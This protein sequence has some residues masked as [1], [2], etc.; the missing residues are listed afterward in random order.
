MKNEPKNI[1]VIRFSSIGDIVLT[2]PVLRCIKKKY[3]NCK[4]HFLSK[5]KYKDAFYANPFIDKEIYWVGRKTL[6]HLAKQDFDWIIDLHKN[7]RTSRIRLFLACCNKFPKWISF[8]KINLPKLLTVWLKSKSFLPKEHIVHRYM[9]PLIKLGIPFDDEGLDYFIESKYRVNI[10]EV[11][12]GLQPFEYNVYALGGQHQT[13]ILPFPK[14]LELLKKINKKTLLLGGKEDWEAAEKLAMELPY[15]IN[16]C[17]KF[18]LPQSA[19]IIEQSRKVY[20][21]DTGLM[22]ISAA[23]LKPIISIWGNTIPEFGMYPFYPVNFHDCENLVLQTKVYCRPC[24]KIGFKKCPHGHFT[25]MN[26]IDF[27]AIS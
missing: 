26:K 14:Q 22:H 5:E 18:K 19:S 16:A 24:S 20:T 6:K 27:S 15:C 23:L 17:G 12:S 21:H 4:I 9:K 11:F 25:C 2:S 1:L 7:L 3:P 10:P 8:N 13:K